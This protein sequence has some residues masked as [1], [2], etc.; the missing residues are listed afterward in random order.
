MTECQGKMLGEDH[1]GEKES[2]I[3][4]TRQRKL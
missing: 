4:V 2:N 3:A 1:I